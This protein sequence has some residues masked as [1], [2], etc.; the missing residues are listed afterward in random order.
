MQNGRA[1]LEEFTQAATGPV[2]GLHPMVFGL[3]L[4]SLASASI[5]VVAAVAAV[6]TAVLYSAAR[7]K[8]GS[9]SD[10]LEVLRGRRSW[11][12]PTLRW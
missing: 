9:H 8:G 12:V 7:F 10:A 3:F 1:W 5:T 6:A 4:L 2:G 11:R